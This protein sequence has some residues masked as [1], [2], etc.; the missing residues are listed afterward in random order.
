[1]EE[2]KRAGGANIAS[3][4]LKACYPF[5]DPLLF[6][7]SPT[8]PSPEFSLFL[9]LGVDIAADLFAMRMQKR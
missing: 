3:R 9:L 6:S 2:E 7:N 1:M 8:A 4:D 5:S